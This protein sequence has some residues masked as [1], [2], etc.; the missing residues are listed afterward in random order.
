MLDGEGWSDAKSMLI[1]VGYLPEEEQEQQ[2]DWQ[3][4]E[5][6]EEIPEINGVYKKYS[7][8]ESYY[9]IDNSGNLYAWGDNDCDQLGIGN[10]EDQP[11]P[12]LINDFIEGKIIKSFEKFDER[13]YITTEDGSTYIHTYLMIL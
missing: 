10:R 12:V 11:S 8:S 3:E 6:L 9:I 7:Y 4:M 1:N 13:V 5:A 2:K